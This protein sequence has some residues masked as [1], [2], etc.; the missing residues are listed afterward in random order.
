MVP[1]LSSLWN[2]LVRPESYFDDRPP[3]ETLGV[4][5]AIVAVFAFALAI[6]ILTMGT[7]LADSTE[8]TETVDNPDRPSEAI[9]EQY[10]DDPHSPYGDRCDEPETIERD[11]S[12]AIMDAVSGYA[13]IGLVS[14]FVLWVL[15]GGVLYAGGRLAGGTPSF[16]GSLALAGWAALPEFGRLAVGL[17]GL[18]VGLDGV[19]LTDPE[20]AVETL[21]VAMEPIDPI[22][23]FVSLLTA[24]IQ[25]RL[26]TGGMI[27]EGELSRPAAA[28]CTGVP[29]GL[30]VLIS[31]A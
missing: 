15:A 24:A 4:A 18:W 7:V 6:S 1:A 9:C 17:G 14:T 26:L 28:L 16:R 27:H 3:A 22:L 21:R 11:G 20:N 5:F 31:L 13:G 29:L 12:D 23:V 2:G 30:F 10:G 25:W 8:I 19:T